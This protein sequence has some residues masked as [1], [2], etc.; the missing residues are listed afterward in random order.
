MIMGPL[1][2]RPHIMINLIIDEVGARSPGDSKLGLLEIG[3]CRRGGACTIIYTYS[4]G[5][6]FNAGGAKRT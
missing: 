2:M 6:D 4:I 3:V 1:L 5:G